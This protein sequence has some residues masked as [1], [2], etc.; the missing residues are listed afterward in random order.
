MNLRRPEYVGTTSEILRVC[1]DPT[2]P[3]LIGYCDLPERSYF[4]IDYA[5]REHVIRSSGTS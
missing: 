2:Q 3:R 5:W 4:G 1:F